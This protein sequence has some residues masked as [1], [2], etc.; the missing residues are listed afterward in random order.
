MITL[1]DALTN[2]IALGFDTAIFQRVA[3]GTLRGLTSVITLS[4]VLVHPLGQGNTPL[5]DA[6]F[7][8]LLN[9]RDFATLSIDAAIA[10]RAAELRARYGLR[11]PD[12]LQI[13]TALIAGCTAFLTNDVRLKRVTEL[14]VLVL[15]DLM[16]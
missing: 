3:N 2:V 12:A 1:D 9:S 8:L 5:R 16:L 7:R 4:E 6:Y 11:T 14:R 10:E 15:D 13:A